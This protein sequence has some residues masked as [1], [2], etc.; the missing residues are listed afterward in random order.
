MSCQSPPALT[1][2]S[3]AQMQKPEN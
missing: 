2:A 1:L 3:S